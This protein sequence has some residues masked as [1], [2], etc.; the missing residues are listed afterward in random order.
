MGVNFKKKYQNLVILKIG[1]K[2]E[3]A[4]VNILLNKPKIDR[5]SKFHFLF[6]V[7]LKFNGC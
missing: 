5:F 6:T 2:S 3:Q 1:N 7:K 4:L